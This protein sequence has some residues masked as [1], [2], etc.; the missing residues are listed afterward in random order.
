[1]E[2]STNQVHTVITPSLTQIIS[3]T[4]L[5]GNFDCI[6]PLQSFKTALTGFISNL[7][8]IFYTAYYYY[9]HTW[10]LLLLL[11]W[12]GTRHHSW[13]GGGILRIL[14]ILRITTWYCNHVDR[15]S[16]ISR[17]LIRNTIGYSLNEHRT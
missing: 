9:V 3:G 11:C 6:C 1:M 12:Y 5:S 15:L 7:R 4:V 14:L 10:W 13:V 17:Q 2:Q 8:Y 16:S